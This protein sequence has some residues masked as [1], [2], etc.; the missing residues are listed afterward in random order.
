MIDA[1]DLVITDSLAAETTYVP[2]SL[3]K[4]S[5]L[6]VQA[7]P[8]PALVLTGTLPSGASLSATF[9]VTVASVISGTP[10]VNT[11][12][13]R[14]RGMPEI[15]SQVVHTTLT[16]DGVELQYL[17]LPLIHKAAGF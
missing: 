3:Q 4:S 10:L 8:S 9:Q 6:Y 14:A 15:S 1:P 2:G 17:F 16:S 13:V 7:L 11:T 5:G 12:H